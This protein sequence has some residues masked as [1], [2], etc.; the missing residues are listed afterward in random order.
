MPCTFA[1]ETDVCSSEH[2]AMQKHSSRIRSLILEYSSFR[3]PGST[4]PDASL[5]SCEYVSLWYAEKLLAAPYSPVV[6]PDVGSWPPKPPP[7]PIAKPLYA[8]LTAVAVHVA[9]S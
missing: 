8:P 5:T 6:R 1:V 4:S 2:I 3:F 7:W 9:L